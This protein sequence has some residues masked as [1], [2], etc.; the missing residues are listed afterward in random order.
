MVIGSMP[1]NVKGQRIL[2]VKFVACKS[3][4]AVYV[5]FLSLLT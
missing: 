3:L 5:S 1:V 2:F 4:S